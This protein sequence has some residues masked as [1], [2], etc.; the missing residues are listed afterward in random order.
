MQQQAAHF[1]H[2]DGPLKAPYS[3]RATY[4]HPSNEGTSNNTHQIRPP[5]AGEQDAS[6]LLTLTSQ[7]N[8]TTATGRSCASTL[9]SHGILELIEE[10]GKNAFVA[11]QQPSGAPHK[12]RPQNNTAPSNQQELSPAVQQDSEIPIHAKAAVVALTSAPDEAQQLRVTP[13]NNFHV[14]FKTDRKGWL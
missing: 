11:P 7:L 2:L 6:P 14:D 1:C 12:T 10:H 13:E 4:T 8:L 5:A 9:I 3:P